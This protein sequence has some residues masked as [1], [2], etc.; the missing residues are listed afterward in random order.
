MAI[1]IEF[2]DKYVYFGPEAGLHL[3]LIHISRD[4]PRILQTADAF[5]RL[6]AQ[7]LEG[8][9]GGEKSADYVEKVLQKN[10]ELVSVCR[11]FI[12]GT[13]GPEE[14]REIFAGRPENL[15]LIHI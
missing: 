3:S 7:M 2:K 8:V 10:R 13:I 14:Y 12:E 15:S 6:Y 1:S 5:S 11:E 9:K 4:F